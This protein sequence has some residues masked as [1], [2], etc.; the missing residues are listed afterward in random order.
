MT[1]GLFGD[2]E[3]RFADA[4]WETAQIDLTSSCVDPD[5]SQED[6]H[7]VLG[8]VRACPNRGAGSSGSHIDRNAVP[9]KICAQRREERQSVLRD[10]LLKDHDTVHGVGRSILGELLGGDCAA[11][12]G[13]LA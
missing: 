11:P 8:G 6:V 7:A 12:G 4:A 5:P 1:E 9:C 10:V 3:I 2:D 13:A